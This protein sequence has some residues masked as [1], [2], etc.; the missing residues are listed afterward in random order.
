MAVGVLASLFGL[1]GS[2]IVLA[3]I[4]LLASLTLLFLVK[5]TYRLE[6]VAV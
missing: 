4:G 6:P 1:Q 5:E 2:A 3:G